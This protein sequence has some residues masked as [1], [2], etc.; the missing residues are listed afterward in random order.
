MDHS[1]YQMHTFG[2]GIRLVHRRVS[3]PVAHCGLIIRAGSRDESPEQHGLAHFIEHVIFKGTRK[4]KA[5]HIL[6]RMENVGGDLNAFT[7][8]EETCIHASFLPQ[9]YGRTLELFSDILDNSTYP[10]K[11]LAKEKDII[12]D[13]IQSYQDSPAEQ[14]FDDIE[15]LVFAGHPLGHPILGTSE[16]LELL[17]K[18][19]ILA[20]TA[21]HHGGP[22]IVIASVGDFPFERLRKLIDRYFS[23]HPNGSEPNGR[24]GVPDFNPTHQA[25]SRETFQS[26]CMLAGL[27]PS[28]DSEQRLPMILLNN[29][30]G[31]PGMNTRL[32]LGIRERYGFCYSIESHYSPYTDAGIFLTYFGV[33]QAYVERTFELVRKELARL[34]NTAL[35]SMQLHFAKKQLEGQIAIAFESNLAEMIS[36]GKSLHQYG[37][38]DTIEEINRKISLID[39]ASLLE[40]AQQVFDTD[41]LSTLVYT[42]S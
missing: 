15:D 41:M 42:P 40:I 10:E 18:E 36:M 6:S 27:A 22:S 20:F 24:M 9:Y 32:N 5:Y 37:R 3:S 4:R 12:R 16:S 2:N 33:E 7:T 11:E 21:R 14:I 29:I 26:H 1:P 31:G 8:K 28:A 38:I 30:L 19:E 17:G 13:E 25:I 34:R 35:G 39:S 23:E